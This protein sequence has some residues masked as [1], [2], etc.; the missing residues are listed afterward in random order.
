MNTSRTEFLVKNTLIFALG[1]IATKL[2]GF[3]LIPLYTAVLDTVQYGTID[4]ITTISTI[5]IPI[6]TLN[7]SE[8][9]MRFNLDKDVDKSAITQ[10]GARVLLFG[11][12]IG[13]LIIP[14]C[15]L[16]IEI[17]EYSAYLYFYI[18]SIASSQIF[19][20]DLRGK[21]LLVQ[22]SIGNVIQTLMVALLNIT[23]LIIF[24]W[25]VKGYLLAYIISNF[26]TA[27]YAIL[28]G[29]G[30][31]AFGFLSIDLSKFKEMIRYSIV[32]IPNSFMWWIM[33]SL[34]H[35][36]VSSMIGIAANG[37]Y[38]ISY[39]LPTLISTTTTIFNQAWSYSAI[40]ESGSDD[41]AEFHNI[42]FNR[43]I[44]IIM[45][46]GILM[47]VFIK[48]FLKV[49]V[50]N[51]YYLSWKYTPFLIV[52]CVYLTLASFI[53]TSYTVHKDSYGYLFSG[54]F[55]AVLNIILNI[56]LIPIIDIYGAAVATCISYIAVFIFRLFHSQ[57]YI[58]YNIHNKN[59]IIGSIV[60][61]I[62]SVLIYF[63]SIVIHIFQYIL[64]VYIVFFYRHIWIM[65]VKSA[66]IEIRKRIF[67]Q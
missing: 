67:Y 15:N 33:N 62:S 22:Y 50:S 13:I 3:F 23:F 29:K 40:K 20:C 2:I 34:D 47:V 21:E 36:M 38:A 41:E 8:A 46:I 24:R 44:A 63:D 61:I 59:F 17:S 43:L 5:V 10:I 16:Y 49:Y 7:I 42:V 57:K 66:V 11:A 12:I 27:L 19:L 52:G 30:Y 32:L 48:P 31:K 35:I 37:I 6:L 25:Q 28:I 39:K 53:G 56:V 64:T 51:E 65:P 4:L 55:G 54:I 45:L 60:L 26:L 18:I 14:C 58:V 9:V 1:N